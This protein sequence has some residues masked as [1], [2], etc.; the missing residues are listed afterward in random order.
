M[1]IGNEDITTTTVINYVAPTMPH[2]D[3]YAMV[4]ITFAEDFDWA[5][6]PKSARA[7]R[8]TRI[9]FTPNDSNPK[10]E[11]GIKRLRTILKA[12]EG[13]KVKVLGG[14]SNSVTEEQFLARYT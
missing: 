3:S 10:N 6:L 12:L 2:H 14:Y 4:C 13:S 1:Y 9:D 5:S 8:I 11:S 7:R